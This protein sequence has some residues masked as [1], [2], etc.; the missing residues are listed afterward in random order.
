MVSY[1][2]PDLQEYALSF[3]FASTVLVRRAKVSRHDG[4]VHG[5][6]YLTQGYGGGITRQDVSAPNAALG[7]NQASTLEGE[8][9]LFKIRL[10]KSRSLSQVAYR[11]RPLLVCVKGQRNQSSAGVISSGRNAHT[12][13]LRLWRGECET[14]RKPGAG[15]V[16][17]VSPQGADQDRFHEPTTLEEGTSQ[18]AESQRVSDEERLLTVP[19][20]LLPAF[21]RG[22]IAD[23]VPALLRHCIETSSADPSKRYALEDWMPEP[24]RHA[25]QVVLLVLDG[26]GWHQ[27]KSHRFL[28]PTLASGSGGA[29]TSVAPSTTA[30]ALTSIATGVPPCRHGV[31]GY[32]LMVRSSSGAPGILD[33][34]RW[35]VD[36]RD[37]RREVR[38]WEF[39]REPAFLGHP[40][41]VVTR[42]DF[43][44]TG[45]TELHFPRA[46]ARPWF[47]AST[48]AVEVAELLYNGEP[49]V[50]AYYD[51]IDKIAHSTGLSD[52]YEAELRSADKLVAELL[53][54]LPPGAALL[55][56]AD[57]GQVEVGPR[58]LVAES[59][60]MDLVCFVS[61]EGRFRWFHA[62]DGA[63]QELLEGAK[64]AFGAHAWVLTKD[65]MEQEGWFGG[66]LRE[67]TR[68]LLGDVAVVAYEPVAVM[69][70]AHTG[71]TRQVGRHGSVTPEEME[72]PLIAWLAE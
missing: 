43:A 31:V 6:D 29:I 16:P 36:G 71:E 40:V 7:T 17:S 38:P 63:Q 61:G 2:R 22:S 10:R 24:V 64:E 72:V 3:V 53:E 20:P 25:R 12:T 67:E 47:V 60:L 51:G 8:K 21:G 62:K 56:T 42:G 34:L 69:D 1:I 33:V 19:S 54:V 48:I 41:P 37:A 44:G 28:A 23:V 15:S 68:E 46:N 18:P 14:E 39:Q 5:A 49:L 57:H 58:M 26:L 4:S 52:A 70:P 13:M 55:V 32:R 65:Q 9:D 45:F 66:P 50:Y 11:G 30:V 27:L 59:E 35:S